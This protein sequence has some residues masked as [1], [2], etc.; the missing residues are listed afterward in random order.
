MILVTLNF[1]NSKFQR[2]SDFLKILVSE[3]NK[4]HKPDLK[5]ICSIVLS[6]STSLGLLNLDHLVL[7]SGSYDCDMNDEKLRL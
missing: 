5:R 2:M 4:I 3:I 6:I 7:Q 1:P